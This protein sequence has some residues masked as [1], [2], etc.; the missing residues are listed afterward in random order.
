M[1]QQVLE[2]FRF[3]GAMSNKAL[4]YL[5]DMHPG[6]MIVLDDTTHSEVVQGIL[7]AAT[8]SFHE[9]IEYRTVT[10]ER[11]VRV[12]T[13]P[14]RC[15]WW[16]AKVE[17]SGNYQ[18]LNRMLTCWIDDSPKQDVRVLSRVLAKDES[19]PVAAVEERQEVLVC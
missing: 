1:L 12:C 2:R 16:V 15:V 9:P 11:K 18:L 5:D 6:S 17:G 13:I 19:V 4:F 14:E 7:K 8:T 3:K 10:K